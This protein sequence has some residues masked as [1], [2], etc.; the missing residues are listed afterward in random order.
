MQMKDQISLYNELVEPWSI[1][2][3]VMNHKN[4][5]SVLKILA[6]MAFQITRFLSQGFFFEIFNNYTSINEHH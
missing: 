1:K 3:S 4:N 5:Y 2:K 6:I